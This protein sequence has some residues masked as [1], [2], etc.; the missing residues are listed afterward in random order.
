MRPPLTLLALVAAALFGASLIQ[1]NE[2]YADDFAKHPLDP[3]D[4]TEYSKV[5]TLLRKANRVDDTSLN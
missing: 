1:D 4:A 2:A 5:V 3:L